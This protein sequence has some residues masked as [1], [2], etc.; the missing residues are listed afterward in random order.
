MP[1]VKDSVAPTDVVCGDEAVSPQTDNDVEVT[2]RL[3]KLE[4]LQLEQRA[5]QY[6]ISLEDFVRR[7]T[8]GLR[9]PRF[10]GDVFERIQA[11]LGSIDEKLIDLNQNLYLP[12]HV[13]SHPELG[14][15]LTQLTNLTNRVKSQ[16]DS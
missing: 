6:N 5:R 8:L 10:I 12:T 15:E 2:L 9:F 16:L 11:T 1:P 4:A 3:S 7:R 14:R 13:A